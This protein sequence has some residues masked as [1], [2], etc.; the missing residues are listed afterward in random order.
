MIK[1]R[2][3]SMLSALDEISADT[4]FLVSQYSI[5]SDSLYYQVEA[6]Y[7]TIETNLSTDID[8]ESIKLSVE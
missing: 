6:K 5:S 2:S 8:V 1:G 3:I 4:Q 7:D